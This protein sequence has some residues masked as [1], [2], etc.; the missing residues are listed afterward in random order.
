MSK[1]EE[2]KELFKIE[3]KIATSVENIQGELE[4]TNQALNEV[5]NQLKLSNNINQELVEVLK[6]FSQNTCCRP[7]FESV[8][9]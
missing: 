2:N 1:E 5:A 3:Q 8:K 4:K 7:T 9:Q 6:T